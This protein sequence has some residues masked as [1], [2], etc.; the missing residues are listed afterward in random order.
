MNNPYISSIRQKFA[1]EMKDPYVAN[2]IVAMMVT[3][4]ALHPQ[5]VLESLFNRTSYVNS[6][7]WNKTL[8][9]MIVGGFYGPYNRHMYPQALAEVR[10]SPALQNRLNTAIDEVLAGSNLILGYTDQ[11]LPTDPNGWR[12]PQMRIGGDVFNDW[13]GGPGGHAGAERWRQDF[14][15]KAKTVETVIVATEGAT[16]ATIPNA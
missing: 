5:P 14:L 8:T 2:L 10:M 4:D 16:N 7:G 3:E 1:E 11:G 6:S 13:E 12:K 15:S 9:Q